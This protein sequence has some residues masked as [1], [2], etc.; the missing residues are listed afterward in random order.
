M[1]TESL[2]LLTK[3]LPPEIPQLALTEHFWGSLIGMFELNNMA[4]QVQSPIELYFLAADDL[5]EPERSEV[6]KE[7]SPLLDALDSAYDICVEVMVPQSIRC[8]CKN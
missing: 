4:L 1:G 6:L 8:V 3:A 5:D 2:R 7:T